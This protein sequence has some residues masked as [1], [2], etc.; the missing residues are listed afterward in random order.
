[1]WLSE[2]VL[3]LHLF[4]A[5]QLNPYIKY[6]PPFNSKLFFPVVLSSTCKSASAVLSSFWLFIAQFMLQ[7]L[8]K[9]I[10]NHR[11]LSQ[12]EETKCMWTH[13]KDGS[14]FTLSWVRKTSVIVET[15][16]LS[17]LVFMCAFHP[18][19]SSFLRCSL[20]SIFS[21]PREHNF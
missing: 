4:I 2:E 7:T 11:C 14:T 21:L 1:M 10:D 16:Q 3:Q 18:E 19:I 15:Y 5:R 6:Y 12:S 20:Y 13:N 17:F 8:L 9:V